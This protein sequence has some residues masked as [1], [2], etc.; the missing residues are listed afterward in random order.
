V[1]NAVLTGHFGTRQGAALT[2]L[3]AVNLADRPHPARLIRCT[4]LPGH[5][6]ARPARVWRALALFMALLFGAAGPGFAQAQSLGPLGPTTLVQAGQLVSLAAAGAAPAGARI[7]VLPG[8]LD[9]RLRLAACDQVEIYLPAG[10]RTLSATRVGLRCKQPGVTPWNVYLPVTVRLLAPGVV[11]RAA[12]PAGAVLEAGHLQI[13]EVDWAAEGSPG[14]ADTAPLLGRTLARPLAAGAAPR[15][16]DIK[17]RLW[18][19]AGDSVRVLARGE[20]FSIGGDATAMSP[21]IEGQTARV[22]T[23]AGRII[24][25]MPVGERRLEVAL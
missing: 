9:P 11:T 18:F 21:G 16:A 15:R 10:T 6:A 12:L 8:S 20:G 2:T 19:A 1:I 5:R 7:E 14:F 22:R 24:T 17:P 25:G 4:R 23:E 13:A 3:R